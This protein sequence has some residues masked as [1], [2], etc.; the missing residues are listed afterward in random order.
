[1]KVLRNEKRILWILNHKT[2]M[3]FE[4]PLLIELGFEVFVPKIIPKHNFRSAEVTFQYDYSLN[5]PSSIIKELNNFNFYEEKWSKRIT[6]IVN[7]YFSIVFVMPHMHSLSEPVD[8]F[9]GE[10]FLRAFGLDAPRTYSDLID[11]LFGRR[12]RY[13]IEG[14]GNRFHF[15][16]GYREILEVEDS[17]LTNNSVYLP[18]GM[19]EN[20]YLN[21]DS[22][23]GEINR[24]LFLC[25]NRVSSPYYNKQFQ[26]FIQAT[27]GFNYLVVDNEDKPEG[28][29]QVAYK[30]STD[31]LKAAY[32]QSAVFY[33]PAKEPRHILYSPIE[34]V[35]CGLP[36]VFHSESLLARMNPGILKGRCSSVEEAH[37]IL[38]DLLDQNVEARKL[39]AKEQSGL[40]D[41]FGLDYIRPIWIENFVSLTESRVQRKMSVIYLRE[42][43]RS[44]FKP[45]FRGKLSWKRV[46]KLNSE[47]DQRLLK[48]DEITSEHLQDHL[49]IVFSEEPLKNVSTVENISAAE[50]F[51]RWSDG[52]ELKMDFLQF[53]PKKFIFQITG[54]VHPDIASQD[55]IVSAGKNKKRISLPTGSVGSYSSI[56]RSSRGSKSIYIFLNETVQPPLDARHVSIAI[57]SIDIFPLTFLEQLDLAA[58]NLASSLPP[59]FKPLLSRIYLKFRNWNINQDESDD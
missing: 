57:S 29:D 19:P 4:V 59:T 44:I 45:M 3:D 13:K 11:G 21:Q 12:M 24:V 5:L 46:G 53:L 8:K 30:L 50:S 7:R 23:T 51:G 2:L 28:N 25:S 9:E 10:I 22:Y 27:R 49:R 40:K 33:T 31:E 18:I 37:Q 58:H 42:L 16:P 48:L 55:F 15:S 43:K 35:I 34:A 38:S 17:F 20:F 56:L 14:L 47:I 1:M 52:S 41:K 39:F 26:N 32:A 36:I 54:F 6:E